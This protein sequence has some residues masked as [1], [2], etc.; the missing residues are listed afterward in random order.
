M[1]AYWDSSALILALS[2]RSVRERL[3]RDGGMTRLHSLSEI[4][5]TLTGG[6]L[7][8]R[9]EADEATQMIKGLMQNLE[10]KDL[11]SDETLEALSEAKAKGVRGGRVYDYLHAATSMK[12]GCEKIYTLNLRDFDGLFDSLEIVEP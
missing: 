3:T 7:G 1:K 4:F 12:F 9:V 8:I 10:I 11:E 5:S 2:E 6:R